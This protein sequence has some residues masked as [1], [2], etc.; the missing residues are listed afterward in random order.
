MSLTSRHWRETKEDILKLALLK[1]GPFAINR[2]VYH[3][4]YAYLRELNK[5]LQ[6]CDAWGEVTTYC[7]AVDAAT[8]S[9]QLQT[10]EIQ[11]PN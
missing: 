4:N 1:V 7:A 2:I 3:P 6:L 5:K 8:S 11:I 10:I 9:N